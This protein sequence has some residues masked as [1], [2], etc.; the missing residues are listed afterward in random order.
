MKKPKPTH[1]CHRA[2]LANRPLSDT[3]SR[4]FNEL[5]LNDADQPTLGAQS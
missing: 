5:P 1:T 3:Q 2:W 4:A